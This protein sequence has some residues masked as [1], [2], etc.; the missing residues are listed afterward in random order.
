MQILFVKDVLRVTGSKEKLKP[1]EILL[2]CCAGICLVTLLITAVF[3]I[4]S[5]SV[6]NQYEN[7]GTES[8]TGENAFVLLTAPA[9]DSTVSPTPEES[10]ISLQTGGLFSASETAV[11]G[12][13]SAP[14]TSV[15]RTTAKP[16]LPAAPTAEP[17]TQIDDVLILNVKTKKIHSASCSYVNNMNA[18]NKKQV[19]GA[20]IQNCLDSGYT[21]CSRC[22]ACKPS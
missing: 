13:V 7:G 1:V 16:S 17:S 21:V 19:S 22:R 10:E 20:E 4:K 11:S 6:L 12:T 5:V 14:K 2:F 8:T 9:S 18:E 3:Q 15:P